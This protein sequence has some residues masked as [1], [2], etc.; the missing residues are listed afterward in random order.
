MVNCVNEKGI[1]MFAQLRG[2]RSGM[3]L[4]DGAASFFVSTPWWGWLVIFLA[5][6]LVT[7]FFYF[8]YTIYQSRADFRLRTAI[9]LSLMA[10]GIVIPIIILRNVYGV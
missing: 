10:N 5:V 7:S 4:A 9:Y 8:C 1:V 6:S 2:A 3:Q